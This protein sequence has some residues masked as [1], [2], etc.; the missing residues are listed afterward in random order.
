MESVPPA[1]AILRLAEPALESV[2]SVPKIH[3]LVS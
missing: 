3:S 2:G 1:M